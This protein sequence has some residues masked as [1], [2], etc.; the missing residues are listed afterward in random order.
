MQLVLSYFLIGWSNSYSVLLSQ[1]VSHHN[2]GT[3]SRRDHGIIQSL[4]FR[5]NPGLIRINFSPAELL[6]SDDDGF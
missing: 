3:I 1:K 5:L 6:E 2:G 4:N